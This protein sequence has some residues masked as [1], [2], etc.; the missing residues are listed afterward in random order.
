L[1]FDSNIVIAPSRD[2]GPCKTILSVVLLWWEIISRK[3]GIFVGKNT[4]KI[5]KP[6]M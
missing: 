5:C 2:M 3:L 4:K 6:M 1:P